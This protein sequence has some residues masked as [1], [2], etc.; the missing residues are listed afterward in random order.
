MAADESTGKQAVA[1]AAEEAGYK[2][3]YGKPPLHTRFRKGRSGNP[4][5]RPPRPTDL[6]S[7]LIEALDRPNAAEGPNAETQ[8]ET[9][10]GALVDKS[11]SGDLPA[12]KRRLARLAGKRDEKGSE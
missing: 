9:I 2:V 1:E 7:L 5:G 12:T 6:A 8:R 11:A 10:V 3:G 4:R